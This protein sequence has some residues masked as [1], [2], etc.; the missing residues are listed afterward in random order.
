MYISLSP[1][2]LGVYQLYE[3]VDHVELK[4]NIVC[5][6]FDYKDGVKYDCFLKTLFMNSTYTAIERLI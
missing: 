3:L 1:N 6:G 5:V 4:D 2:I